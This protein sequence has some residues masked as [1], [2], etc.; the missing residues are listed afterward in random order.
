MRVVNPL[1]PLENPHK[2]IVQHFML[3]E[4]FGRPEFEIVCAAH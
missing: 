1:D 3:G 4:Q 2:L